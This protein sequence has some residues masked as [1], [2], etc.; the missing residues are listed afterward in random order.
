MHCRHR[1]CVQQGLAGVQPLSGVLPR[2]QGKLFVQAQKGFNN[3]DGAEKMS[4]GYPNGVRAYPPGEAPGDSGFSGQLELIYKATSQLS[5]VAFLDGGYIWRWNDPFPGALQPNS[6][7]LAGTGIG[8]D[9]GTPGEWLA[10]LKLAF[11]IGNNPASLNDTDADGFN[12]SLRVWGS[13]RLWF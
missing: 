11:P 4:L 6:Y 2:W 5:F 8:A 12:K 10:S 3:L 1:W 9:L 13:L 7:G